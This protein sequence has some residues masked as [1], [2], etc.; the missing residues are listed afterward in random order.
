MRP[1]SYIGNRRMELFIIRHGQSTNNVTMAN[2][3]NN[4]MADPPLTDLGRQ[5]AETLA[6]HLKSGFDPDAVFDFPPEERGNAQ[7]F[8]I[9]RLYCSPMLR[10]LQ[11]CQPIS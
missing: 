8:G 9:T 7:G 10:T 1:A 2:S 11:T 3:I 4:R 5:Q 6:Q